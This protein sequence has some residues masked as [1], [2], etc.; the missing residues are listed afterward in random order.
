MNKKLIAAAIA[1]V[2]AAPVV[3]A[4]D[5]TLY[6]KAHVQIDV[7]DMPTTEEGTVNSRGSRVGIKGSEDLGNGLKAIFKYEMAYD[8]D[9]G[10]GIGGARN[11]YVGLAGGFG[12][13]LAGRHDTPAKVALYATGT[14]LLAGSV[15]QITSGGG[16]GIANMQ[17]TRSSNVIAYISPKFSGFSGAIAV[18]PNE[19]DGDDSL[20]DHWSAG[21]MYS[22]GGLK[23][24]VGY[25]DIDGAYDMYNVG[26][27]YTMDMFTVG[28]VYQNQEAAV[29]S[30]ESEMWALTGKANFGNNA[31]I[32]TY[33]NSETGATDV[34]GL[35]LAV[36][37]SFSKRS[38]VY[39]AYAS[40][41]GA[42]TS[43]AGD[44]LAEQ[45]VISIGMIHDF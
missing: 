8:I 1:A 21:L 12:T 33:A 20:T 9:G 39:A 31:L 27:S 45:D 43:V 25:E 41:D 11:S 4:A 36:T 44:A 13:V 23:A 18:I 6:G 30:A 32:L 7:A 34:D 2:M 28:A 24:G 5:T 37:H 3:S 29:G 40:T 14:E 38:K 15:I 17:E 19:A 16:V 42:V 35:G 22:G 26:A 10:T